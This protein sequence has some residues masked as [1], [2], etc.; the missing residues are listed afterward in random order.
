MF[1]ARLRIGPVT[2]SLKEMTD[3]NWRTI[4]TWSYDKKMCTPRLTV[5]EQKIFTLEEIHAQKAPAATSE[6]MHLWLGLTSSYPS[7][8]NW[9]SFMPVISVTHI[10]WEALNLQS[11]NDFY[12]QA[13]TMNTSQYWPFACEYSIWNA[14]VTALQVWTADLEPHIL[15]NVIVWVYTAFFYGDYT[16]QICNLPEEMLFSCFVAT[17]N[18]AF[19]TELA[20]EDEGYESGSV[21]FNIPTPLST[22]PRIYHVS[23]REDLS[24]NPVN[25]GQ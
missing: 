2:A 21:N 11:F 25:F 14:T 10:Y 12:L 6:D 15:S 5:K 23:T 8:T 17:M 3:L 1:V 22:A 4:A 13:S 7:G 24:F 18:D 19:E 20:K 16:Q 9:N